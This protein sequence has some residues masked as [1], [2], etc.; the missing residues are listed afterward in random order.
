[1]YDERPTTTAPRTIPTSGRRRTRTATV[2][3]LTAATAALGLPPANADVNHSGAPINT[4]RL[5]GTHCRATVGAV[6]T[7]TGAAMG[8]VDVTCR[9]RYRIVARAVEYRWDGT[10][11]QH[12]SS[13]NFRARTRYLSVHTG[14]ICGG[15][16]AQWVTIAYVTIGRRHYRHLV[17]NSVTSAYIPPDC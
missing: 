13:G 10:S 5:L 7:T 3:A 17:S 9:G 8:G 14:A 2:L 15:G 6:K 1:M 11:W 4:Y 16:E 12:W